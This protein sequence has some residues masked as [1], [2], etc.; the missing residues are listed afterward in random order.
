[1]C[2]DPDL[3]GP[4]LTS[5]VLLVTFSLTPTSLRVLHE[6]ADRMPQGLLRSNYD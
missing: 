1:M 6:I 4:P 5:P 2:I 3:G